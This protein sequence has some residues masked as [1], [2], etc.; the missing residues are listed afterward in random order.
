MGYVDDKEQ[1]GK[2]ASKRGRQL[3][4]VVCLECEA[5][6]RLDAIFCNRCGEEL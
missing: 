6:N 3:K 1:Q 5:K 4:Y 2:K